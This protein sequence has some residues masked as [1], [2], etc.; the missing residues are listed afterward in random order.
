M[1]TDMSTA[2]VFSRPISSPLGCDAG[3]IEGGGELEPRV[4][5]LSWLLG[6]LLWGGVRGRIHRSGATV[7]AVARGATCAT[8]LTVD[9][10]SGSSYR[11]RS[12]S[13]I[14]SVAGRHHRISHPLLLTRPT[15]SRAQHI[16]KRRCKGDTRNYRLFNALQPP[17]PRDRPGAGE[18]VTLWLDPDIDWANVSQTRVLALSLA[19]EPTD[20][21]A[22]RLDDLDKPSGGRHEATAS[23]RRC[24]RVSGADHRP[25]CALGAVLHRRPRDLLEE[26]P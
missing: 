4:Q 9:G 24:P 23:W 6:L 10:P 7:A 15:G 13:A 19:E 21:P 12:W 1:S 14:E 11:Y 20:R 25:G 22:H 16:K 18:H 17:V 26:F 2:G 5:K 8:V 3:A